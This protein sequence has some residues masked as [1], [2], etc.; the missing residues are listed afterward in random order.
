MFT[1]HLAQ[2]LAQNLCSV[3]DKASQICHEGLS[4]ILLLSLLKMEKCLSFLKME[5][6][7]LTAERELE[8]AVWIPHLS[9][10]WWERAKLPWWHIRDSQVSNS[11]SFALCKNCS[12]SVYF[13]GSFLINPLGRKS[14]FCSSITEV[15]EE[16][17]T[18][19]SKAHLLG[20]AWQQ[21]S[22]LPPVWNTQKKRDLPQH[23]HKFWEMFTCHQQGAYLG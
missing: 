17:Q 10:H 20:N 12:I 21:A 18:D 9:F 16:G 4:P 11:T 6:S 13:I 14:I 15:T 23:V 7:H 1:K 3:S 5:E 8:M 2:C 19:G 22:K